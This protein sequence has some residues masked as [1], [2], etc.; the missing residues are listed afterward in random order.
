MVAVR[1]VK[2]LAWAA[3]LAVGATLMCIGIGRQWTGSYDANGA[4]YSTAARN[5]LRHGLAATRGG[6]VFNAGQLAPGDFRFYAH[7]PPGVSL[8]IAASFA[9]FGQR[10]WAARL[11][12]VALTLA[13]IALVF[14]VPR[15]LGGRLAGFFAALLLAVQPMVAFYGRMPDHEAPAAFFV[16]AQAACYVHWRAAGE[17]QWLALWCVAAFVG[18]WFAWVVVL[19]PFLLLGVEWLATRRLPA[20]LLAPVAA[21]ATGFASV[22]AHVALVAGGL[23][24]LWRALALR[25]GSQ[26][27]AEGGGVARF[28]MLEFLGRHWTYFTT[29]FSGVAGCVALVWLAGLRVRPRVESLLVGAL[30]ALA[31]VNIVAFRQGSYVHIYYQYYLALPLAMA[32][33][34]A[35]ADLCRGRKAV[36]F[37]LALWVALVAGAEGW[38]KLA[39]IRGKEFYLGQMAAAPKLRQMT[40]PSDRVLILYEGHR[41]LRQ[42]AY[43]ADR[44]ITQVRTLADAAALW[45]RGNYTRALKLIEER[46]PLVEERSNW[47]LRIEAIDLSPEGAVLSEVAGCQ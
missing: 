24:E 32:A 44:N 15:L 14:H 21:G 41:S 30:A 12:F 1:A 35:L 17:R 23:G 8:A 7:H 29:A 4:L 11:P 9:A 47:K 42:L 18:A 5:H 28:G 26:V 31:L 38:V 16:L 43:Y 22:L 25:A 3:P 6:Q 10:E 40:R 37:L 27:A 20:R 13:S 2:V 45:R 34:R 46:D 39:A 19:M 33:G 36:W